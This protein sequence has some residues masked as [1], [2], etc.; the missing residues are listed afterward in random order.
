VDGA[1]DERVPAVVRVYAD[2]IGTSGQLWQ[3]VLIEA[4]IVQADPTQTM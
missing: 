2:C 3:S 1:A 4:E